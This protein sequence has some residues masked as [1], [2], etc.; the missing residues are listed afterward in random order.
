MC[1]LMTD[2]LSIA[3]TLILKYPL[4]SANTFEYTYILNLAIPEK[5]PF[6]HAAR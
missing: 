6:S 4:I 5:Y 3:A 2:P 1:S